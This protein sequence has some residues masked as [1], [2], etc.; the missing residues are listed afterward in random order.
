MWFGMQATGEFARDNSNLIP[1]GQNEILSRGRAEPSMGGK[2][3][4]SKGLYRHFKLYQPVENSVNEMN[5][6]SHGTCLPRIF[7]SWFFVL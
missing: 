1:A 2:A 6:K 3:H 5:N 4:E 7:S